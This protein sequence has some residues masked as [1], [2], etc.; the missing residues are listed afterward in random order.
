MRKKPKLPPLPKSDWNLLMP[1]RFYEPEWNSNQTGYT[2]YDME[3][4][5][6]LATQQLR[7]E[8]EGFMKALLISR[9]A[10]DSCFD[11]GGE[12]GPT[13]NEDKVETAKQAIDAALK[14]D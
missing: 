14:E 1:A 3:S 2:E 7:E 6:I 11:M 10:L 5:A 12:D 13:I 8:V 9:E 4:Y